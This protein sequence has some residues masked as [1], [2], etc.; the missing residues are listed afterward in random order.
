MSYP[1]ACSKPLPTPP[2]PEPTV[3]HVVTDQAGRSHIHRCA[4]DGLVLGQVA[5]DVPAVWQA[6]AV[7]DVASRAIWVLPTGWH[8]GWHRNPTRQWVIPLT[9]RWF[10]ET[11]DGARV[12]MGPGDMHLG[13]D[14]NSTP[15]E[16]GRVGAAGYD[17][18]DDV[19]EGERVH[20]HREVG[21]GV[22]RRESQGEPHRCSG[23]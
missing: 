13:D 7:H 11:Q 6:P 4:I 8:G 2:A 23:S 14:V 21:E 20:P 18:L 1:V 17:H 5:A 19:H 15:D 3:L 9:G 16:R 12:E 10:V 22:G